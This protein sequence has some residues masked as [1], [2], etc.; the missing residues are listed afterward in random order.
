MHYYY[1]NFSDGAEIVATPMDSV[2]LT[3]IDVD[4]MPILPEDISLDQNYPN[5]FNLSTTITYQINQSCHINLTIYD[6]LG[7]P[8]TEVVNGEAYIGTHSAIWDGRNNNGDIVSSGVYFYRLTAGDISL[9][10]KMNLIK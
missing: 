5:P 2:Y 6:I 3:S 7:R 8:I 10:R 4:E 9:V 1:F